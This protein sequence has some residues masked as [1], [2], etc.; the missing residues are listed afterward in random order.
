MRV[1]QILS[2]VAQFAMVVRGTSSICQTQI[3]PRSIDVA[4]RSQWCTLQINT[5]GT[6]CGGVTDENTC[7]I[8]SLC[9]S[10]TCTSNSSSPSLQLYTSTI[11]FFV[12]DQTYS[13]CI[14]A[15]ENDAAA[16][17][18][19]QDTK[20]ANCGTLDP[21]T[22][23]SSASTL[24]SKA[25]VKPTPIPQI[26][27]QS[28]INTN[29]GTEELIT[30]TTKTVTPTPTGTTTVWTTSTA[31]SGSGSV[32]NG[33]TASGSVSVSGSAA[34]SLSSSLGVTGVSSSG[35]S[36]TAASAVSRTSSLE[37]A[38]GTAIGTSAPSTISEGG[39]E[40]TRIGGVWMVWGVLM[41]GG[42]FGVMGL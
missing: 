19:C 21:D 22:V 40:R 24:P 1:V 32:G 8:T 4:T 16:Q 37:T 35:S 11:P 23:S 29:T 2:L 33:T 15:G 18:A 34:G 9:Y 31:S 13:E 20:E 36:S 28:G 5:C 14:A 17:K 41:I 30:S 27:S 6:L 39:A 38:T 3:D 12:C 25:T 26:T 10:C 7:D 42:G